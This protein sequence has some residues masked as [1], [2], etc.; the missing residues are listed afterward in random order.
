MSSRES[1]LTA[2][3]IACAVVVTFALSACA[4]GDD[5][6]LAGGNQQNKPSSCI[7]FSGMTQTASSMAVCLNCSV[8]N[9]GSAVDNNIESAASVIVPTGA[10]GSISFRATA[11]SG[12]IFP[13]G[14][15]AAVV[16]SA[17]LANGRIHALTYH[18]GVLQED[19]TGR[20]TATTRNGMTTVGIR[21]TRNYDAVEFKFESANP[22]TGETAAVREFCSN[23]DTPI[24]A[25]L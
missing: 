23:S 10:V 15:T 25:P 20:S 4:D 1:S 16:L 18:G 2:F 13:A 17:G 19:G 21:T 9:P 11:Q 3:K 12:I 14:N 24:V 8:S 7:P 5:E 6:G 22:S